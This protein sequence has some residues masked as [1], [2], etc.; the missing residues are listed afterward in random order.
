MTP[1]T[2]ADQARKDMTELDLHPNSRRLLQ[3]WR[4]IGRPAGQMPIA[5]PDSAGA[6]AD[7]LF[8]AMRLGPADIILQKVGS[9]T[10]RLFGRMLEGHHLMSVFQPADRPLANAAVRMAE[11][12]YR[13][14]L[15]RAAG[16]TLHGMRGD[17]ELALTPLPRGARSQT[18]L[19][20]LCQ[21]LTPPSR[22]GGLPLQGLHIQLVA[23]PP[24]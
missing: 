21:L 14:V 20:G 17:I 6:P 1:R 4:G 13:P 22:I 8:V 2:I 7:G 9:G 24:P 18:C 5:D 19:L 16:A 15:I 3:S 23:A 10:E 12:T 11:D